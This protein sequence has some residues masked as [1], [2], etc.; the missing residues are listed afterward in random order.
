MSK[1][2]NDISYKLRSDLSKKINR[3]PMKYFDSKTH[4]EILSIITNDIDTLSQSINQSITTIIS[5]IATI[6]GVLIMMISINIPM[7]IATL[8]IIPICMVMVNGVVKKSQKYFTLQQD[9]LVMI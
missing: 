6:I 9:Y 1:V 7:T 4:G 3:L 5:G 8:L 2:S